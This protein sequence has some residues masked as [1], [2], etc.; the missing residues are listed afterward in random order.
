[1]VNW[2]APGAPATA[3]YGEEA[4]ERIV[5][6][7]AKVA[8]LPGTLHRP[9]QRL[10]AIVPEVLHCAALRRLADK[11]QVVGPREGDTPRTRLTHSLE[12]G[13]IGRG[14]AIGLG[15]EPDLVELAGSSPTTSGIRRTD[16]TAN[17]H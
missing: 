11:S 12:V 13:Q 9:P 4:V 17:A 8:S 10:R 6:E 14:I 3:F 5:P 7:A 2:L 1:M 16:T 15:C